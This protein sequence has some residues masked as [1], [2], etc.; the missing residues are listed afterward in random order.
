MS[1]TIEQHSLAAEAVIKKITRTLKALEDYDGA[2]IEPT[3][4]VVRNI[5]ELLL[6]REYRRTLLEKATERARKTLA[7]GDVDNK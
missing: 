4:L 5:D 3:E 6:L 2:R 7:S 1:T